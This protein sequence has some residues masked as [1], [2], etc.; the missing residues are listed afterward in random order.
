VALVSR[1]ARR[2][3]LLAS[4]VTVATAWF[5]EHPHLDPLRYTLI[6]LADDAAY[7]TGVWAGVVRT[8]RLDAVLPSFEPWPP[9]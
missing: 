7:G 8:R 9:R 2:L 6:R 4:A 3:M 5:D 1:R